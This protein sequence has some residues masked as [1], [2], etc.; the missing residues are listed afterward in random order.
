MRP[1][2]EIIRRYPE[3]PT[4]KPLN[5]FVHVPKTA[6]TSL[7]TRVIDRHGPEDT[8]VYSASSGLYFRADKLLFQPAETDTRRVRALKHWVFT[9]V[10][11][12]LIY[13]NNMRA[14][15]ID[16]VHAEANAVIGHFPHTAFDDLPPTR[17]VRKFTVLRNP[18]ARMVSH[19]R[20]LQSYRRV[21]R[22]LLGWMK[23]NNLSLP[24]REFALSDPVQNFQTRLTGT[25]LNE[26]AAVGLTENLS[27]FL[28]LAGL[29]NHVTDA[30]P[31]HNRT[32]LGNNIGGITNDPGFV[33]D[34]VEFHAADY[35]AYEEARMSAL[36]VT[37]Q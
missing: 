11:R 12:G 25:N 36:R 29:A 9:P 32:V 19:Y 33:R 21:G 3:E 7:R 35:A 37:R 15:S 22:H 30:L 26:Y 24:F 2:T 13:C 8:W 34:F 17:E 1:Y 5:V 6:G 28:C 14:D 23:N 31:H 16:E 27:E 4:Q 10:T 20:Y 18:L